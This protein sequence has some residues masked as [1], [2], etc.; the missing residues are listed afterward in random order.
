MKKKLLTREALSEKWIEPSF[1]NGF[2]S[3]FWYNKYGEYHS[4]GDRPAIMWSNG[5]KCWYKNGKYH[6][7]GDKPA[8]IYSDGNKYWYKNGKFIKK[9]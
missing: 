4:I 9:V 5:N 8:I 1:I 2:G 3:M 7:E 6:R